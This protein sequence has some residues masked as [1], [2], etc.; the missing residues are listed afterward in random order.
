MMSATKSMAVHAADHLTAFERDTPRVAVGPD[1]RHLDY[2]VL[3]D[4]NGAPVI[5]MSSELGLVKLP[6]AIENFAYRRGLR[7]ISPIRAGYGTSD[8]MP[9]DAD[10]STQTALDILTVMK[11]SGVTAAPFITMSAD[12]RLA[13]HVHHVCPGAVTAL[14]ATA[15]S[16]PMNSESKCAHPVH[17]LMRSSAHHLV[18]LAPAA[19]N[20]SFGAMQRLGKKRMFERTFAKSADDLAVFAD[21]DTRTAMIEGS[22]TALCNTRSARNAF[23]RQRLSYHEPHNRSVMHALKNAVPVHALNGLT[24]PAVTPQTL[25][26]Q[27]KDYGWINFYIYPDAG[28]WL[29]FKY[30]DDVLELAERYVSR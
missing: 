28:R 20:A 23:L 9:D 5:Y 27:T 2:L 26:A 18:R 21:P 15:G 12:V 11:D 13:A 6:P 14:I 8:A 25:A 1:G 29:F 10:F 7:V 30:P 16:L 24:D 22:N 19:S 3:G 4:P 17:R